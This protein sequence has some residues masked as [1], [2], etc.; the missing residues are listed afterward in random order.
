MENLLIVLRI[1]NDVHVLTLAFA[2]L[3]L[4]RSFSLDGGDDLNAIFEHFK[5]KKRKEKKVK[6]KEHM[7]G[8]RA[9]WPHTFMISFQLKCLFATKVLNRLPPLLGRLS[10][11]RPL[12]LPVEILP[13]FVCPH[14]LG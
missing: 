4:R 13:P 14:A 5:A 10:F 11:T 1:I 12:Y 7:M 8:E 2:N 6:V 9:I 3:L